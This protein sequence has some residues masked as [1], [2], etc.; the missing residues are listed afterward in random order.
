MNFAK[1]Q[2]GWRSRLIT[3]TGTRTRAI[4]LSEYSTGGINDFLLSFPHFAQ[5][6]QSQERKNYL[7]NQNRAGGQDPAKSTSQRVQYYIPQTYDSAQL[8]RVQ[9]FEN[10]WAVARQGPLSM[11]SPG[12][13]TGVGCHFLLQGIFTTQGWNP[14]LLL[15]RQILYHWATREAVQCLRNTKIIIT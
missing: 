14:H 6:S 7:V 2:E 8:S 13:N 11:R 9:L 15:G 5:D 4:Q 3:W 12:K 1:Q 10:P